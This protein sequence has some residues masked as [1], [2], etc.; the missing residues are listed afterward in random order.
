MRP[1]PATSTLTGNYVR[2]PA[3][4][5]P[6]NIEDFKLDLESGSIAYALLSK[7]ADEM[8]PANT[9][10]DHKQQWIPRSLPG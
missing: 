6:V 9:S 1:M 7:I 5:D 4:D 10:K 8:L 2:N 3:G